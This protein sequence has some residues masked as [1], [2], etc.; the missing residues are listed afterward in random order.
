VNDDIRKAVATKT[1]DEA[2]LAAVKQAT[3]MMAID[4]QNLRIQWDNQYIKEQE[5][6]VIRIVTYVAMLVGVL[7]TIVGF[8]LWYFALRREARAT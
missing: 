6:D 8:V 4:A 2:K 3:D 5:A 1:V 7:T